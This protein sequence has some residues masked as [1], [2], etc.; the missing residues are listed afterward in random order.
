MRRFVN[1]YRK[2]GLAFLAV[3]AI[4]VM[5]TGFCAIPSV[6]ATPATLHTS[7]NM[8]CNMDMPMPVGQDMPT[9]PHCKKS[10][11]NTFSN[12]TN[13]VPVSWMLVAIQPVLS[14]QADLVSEQQHPLLI[15]SGAPP[16]SSSLLYHKTLRIRL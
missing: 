8:Q 15:A 14:L 3:F 1:H 2:A 6:H 9:C 11:F 13:D 4:Q 10:N 7:A 5:V 12:Q 16:R